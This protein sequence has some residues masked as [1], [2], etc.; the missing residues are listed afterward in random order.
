MRSYVD[1]LLPI[2]VREAFTYALPESL[3]ARAVVG[4]RAV[5]PLGQRK[6][7]TGVVIRIHG[8]RPPY[9]TVKEVAKLI[10]EKP[11]LTKI[12]KR[13]WE[14][15]AD[16][17]MC[18]E[19]EVMKSTLPSA[20]KP[21]GFSEIFS[22]GYQPRTETRI[23]WGELIT[24]DEQFLRALDS[25][26]RAKT[27]QKALLR[28]VELF[29][30]GTPRENALSRSTVMRLTT[31]SSAVIKSLE[32]KDFIELFE[33][34][35]SR[36]EDYGEG[37]SPLPGLSP[38][39]ETARREIDENL[40]EKDT[41]LLHG[42]TGSGKTEIYTHLI[43][44]VLQEG[45]DVLYLLPEIALTTQLIDRLKNRFGDRMAVCHSRFTAQQRA[46]TY[47]K[48]LDGNRVPLLVLGVRSSVLLPFDNLGLV[49]VDEEHETTYKQQDPAPRYNARDVA[50]VLAG[51]C[52]A[53]TLLGSAT[54]SIESF[55]NATEAGKYGF[56]RLSE[57]YGSGRLPRIVVSDTARAARRGERDGHFSHLLLRE[58]ERVTAA[59]RQA[60]LF[61]NRRGFSPYIECGAC[62][63]VI[64]CPHCNV[65]LTFHK[66]PGTL[67]C[68][69]CGHA[70]PVPSHC[71]SC[72]SEDLQP[73][74]FG[75]EKIEEQLFQLFP[76]LTVGRLDLDSVRTVRSYERI[77]S[78]F[79]FGK[80]DLLVGTQMVTKGFDFGNVALVGIMNADNLLNYPDFRASE[81][82]FQL[83]MQVAGRAG[84]RDDQGMV[85]IQTSQPDHPVIVQVGAGDYEAMVR[86]Q[87]AERRAFLYPPF[88]RLIRFT[89]KHRQKEV[90]VRAAADFDQ[91]LRKLFGARLLGP[92]TP[93]VDKIR[94]EFLRGFLLK[95][96]RHKS[97]AKARHWAGDEVRKLL[98]T[99]EYV[100]LAMVVDVDPL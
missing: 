3:R 55:Y 44:K 32:E 38:A 60:I 20:L 26:G 2:A 65:S 34:E 93:M 81:R 75:T 54:P 88:C 16:Y 96:E 37:L 90:L 70:V 39:Q 41:V 53:K 46:E 92:E 25:L 67:Q 5:V 40:R 8:E 7:Y 35:V 56:V 18:S 68:H 66:G 64:D 23:A 97:F 74:G 83:M 21:A 11:V 84:R 45:R 76:L 99:K 58:I 63:T 98:T 13:F 86:T 4:G 82:S 29:P 1:V 15:I 49:I 52:G 100:G 80:I 14:W 51:L 62:A 48:V 31:C 6:F 85:V 71:A 87:L 47:L 43:D 77:L 36:L 89:L 94:G 91:A 10:D 30:V 61:Q 19:G 12:Q 28:L 17:Y 78:A 27:Q 95:I 50:L 59:G 69:Y 72:G 73:R 9:R 33:A 79:A 57:R 22:D 42:V 24:D